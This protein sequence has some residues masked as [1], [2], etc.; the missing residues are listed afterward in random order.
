MS[1][2]E[3]VDVSITQN[4]RGRGI[5]DE[6]P[7]E[8]ID[9][10]VENNIDDK[11]SLLASSCV[12]KSW[13]TASLRHLFS[14]ANFSSDD[15]FTRWREIGS[16]LPQVPLFVKEVMF[17][18]G[19]RLRDKQKQQLYKQY[20]DVDGVP[21]QARLD[22]LARLLHDETLSSSSPPCVQLPDMPQARKLIWDTP[23]LHPVY[24][25]VS[26]QQFL[27]TFCSLNEVEFS[28]SF[29]TISDA[30]QFLGLLPKIEVLDFEAINIAE[31]SSSGRS[32]AFTGDMTNLRRLSVGECRTS[33]DWLVDDILAVS[34]PTKLQSIRYEHY[35]PFS[36]R[37]FAC[38]VAISS[39]SLQ[40][41]IIQPPSDER[42]SLAG[43]RNPP[44]FTNQSF[45]S[46]MSLTFCIIQL[47][48]P[49][50]P[51]FSM[52]WCRR[53]MEVLPPAPKMTT[54]TMHFYAEEPEDVDDIVA[55]QSFN[56][57]QL[58]ELT[59]E[60]FPELKTFIVHVS[61]ETEFGARQKALLEDLLEER[62]EHFGKKLKIEWVNENPAWG[63]DVE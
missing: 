41:L 20:P 50:G 19:R 13:R 26:T 51:L 57:K 46:L 48:L 40:E 11:D 42:S 58:S 4:G 5:G 18:P 36:S 54:L 34:C 60:L 52:N 62:L 25:T 3:V 39:E 17:A 7:L 43:W 33:L 31:A 35:L 49:F 45:P 24:C 8:L 44:Q 63:G 1:Q 37:V 53:V 27:S 55:D 59:S 38:L 22:A 47:G 56:W 14:A 2:K 30:K 21:P 10:I 61:M 12:S 16:H 28:G 9:T 6:L 23:F 15:D 29:A 32:P